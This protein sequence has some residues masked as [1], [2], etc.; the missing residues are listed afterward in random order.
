MLK[1]IRKKLLDELDEKVRKQQPLTLLEK[2]FLIDNGIKIDI[3][4]E[5]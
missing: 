5:K 3:I 2:R 4:S 1:R